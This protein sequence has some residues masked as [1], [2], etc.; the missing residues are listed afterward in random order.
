MRCILA[1]S[2]T[3]TDVVSVAGAFHSAPFFEQVD[4]IVS[5]GAQGVDAMAC[6]IALTFGLRFTEMP[7]DWERHGRRAGYLRNEDMAL[8]AKETPPGG[9]VAAWDGVSRGTKHMI[10][11]AKKHG[12]QVHVVV[13]ATTDVPV[14]FP[15]IK[16]ALPPRTP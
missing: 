11:L 4:E 16:P 9:L 12:L 1:G 14:L 15:K 8:Y 7:A 3:I 13:L 2:R 5:G 10:D 6:G